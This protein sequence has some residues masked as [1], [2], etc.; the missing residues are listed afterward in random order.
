M[1]EKTIYCVMKC[2]N[3]QKIKVLE[4]IMKQIKSKQ[5][6]RKTKIKKKYVQEIKG[7]GERRLKLCKSKQKGKEYLSTKEPYGKGCK[8]QKFL[9]EKDENI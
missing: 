6:K 3:K 7:I 9:K 4:K 8:Y 2:S 1:R 5:K